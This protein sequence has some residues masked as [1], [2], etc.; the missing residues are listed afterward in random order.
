MT[1]LRSRLSFDCSFVNQV[2]INNTLSGVPCGPQHQRACK[3]FQAGACATV[4]VRHFKVCGDGSIQT[5]FQAR[6]RIFHFPNIQK[7]VAIKAV[8]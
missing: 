2:P 5:L 7:D 8:V 4:V 6:V 3:M 1:R